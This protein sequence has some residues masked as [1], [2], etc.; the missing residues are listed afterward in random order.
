LDLPIKVVITL[1]V[2]FV[3]GGAVI[4][5]AQRTLSTGEQHLN[6]VGTTEQ[7]VE[8][9]SLSA[10]ASASD[11]KKLADACAQIG[12]GSVAQKDCFVVKGTIP[13]GI[14]ALDG[15]PAGSSTV[16]VTASG[17]ATALFILYDP[18]GKVI[19]GS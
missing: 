8:I 12:I 16:Q 13:G 6:T 18:S 11:V 10:A 19:I 2:S 17:S 1:F 15:Q 9:I 5:F 3:V 7:G 4:L 14:A